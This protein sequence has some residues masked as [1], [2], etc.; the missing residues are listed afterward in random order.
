MKSNLG[1]TTSKMIRELNPVIRGW[2]NYHRRICSKK[3]FS[4]I[5]H[6]IFKA[7]WRWARRRHYN[8]NTRWIRKHYF[9]KAGNRAWTFFAAQKSKKGESKIIDLLSMDMI[10]IVRHIKICGN[11]NPY[12]RDWQQYFSKRPAINTVSRSQYNL[13]G[14]WTTGSPHNRGWPSKGLS[15]VMGNYH[16]RFLGGLGP[17][18][19]PGYPVVDSANTA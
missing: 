19:A 3:T 10:R 18:M 8:K 9:R 12:D 2:G 1:H 11:A 17:A 16:A 7:I 6:R 14:S 13:V 4:Y 5:D 15:R